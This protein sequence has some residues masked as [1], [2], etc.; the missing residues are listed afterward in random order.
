M[1][2]IEPNGYFLCFAFLRKLVIRNFVQECYAYKATGFILN[3]EYL[4]NRALLRKVRE[5][6]E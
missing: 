4:E 1:Q 6:L 5:N 3:L 2:F